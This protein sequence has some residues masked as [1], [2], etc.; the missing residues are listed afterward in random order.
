M[1]SSMVKA[2]TI[3]D[4]IRSLR[5]IQVFNVCITHANLIASIGAINFLLGFLIYLRLAHVLE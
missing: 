5:A 1:I 3:P 4:S 2:N